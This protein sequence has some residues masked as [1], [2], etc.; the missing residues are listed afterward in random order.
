MLN[1]GV[2]FFQPSTGES[3]FTMP[4]PIFRS[5]RN[6]NRMLSQTVKRDWNQLY[7]PRRAATA[8]I[9]SRATNSIYRTVTQGEFNNRVTVYFDPVIMADTSQYSTLTITFDGETTCEVIMQLQTNTSSRAREYVIPLGQKLVTLTK[10]GYPDYF[11]VGIGGINYNALY[12][13]GVTTNWT[14]GLITLTWQ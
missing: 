11:G 10:A 2:H 9:S 5:P 8:L 14:P 13:Y 1:I 12:F 7:T 6:L 4:E 3:P